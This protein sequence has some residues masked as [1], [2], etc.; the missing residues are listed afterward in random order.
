VG[1]GAL[2]AVKTHGNA[3][4]IG[5]D[6]DWAVSDP[7]YADIILTSIMKNYDVSVVQAVK[8]IEDSTFTGG[9]HLGTL[10]TGEVGLAPFYQFDS[11][12]PDKVK[13]ELEQIREDIIAG[14]IRTKP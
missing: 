9:V 8:A 4:L 11:L 12:I 6:T 10:E 13:A 2:Y 14:K 3:F 5:V 7:D 1:A